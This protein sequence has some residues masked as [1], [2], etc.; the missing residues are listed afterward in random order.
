MAANG[1]LFITREIKVPTTIAKREGAIEIKS[2]GQTGG[3]TALISF[4]FADRSFPGSARGVVEETGARVT[5]EHLDDTGEVEVQIARTD[6]HGGGASAGLLPRKLCGA[7]P[8]D[9]ATARPTPSGLG[10][11]RKASSPRP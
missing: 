3:G 9:H 10:V 5:S 6:P 4:H 7:A 1:S 2:D 11:I 8:S